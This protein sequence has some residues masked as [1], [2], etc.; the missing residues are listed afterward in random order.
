MS[1]QSQKIN[2]SGQNIENNYVFS[3]KNAKYPTLLSDCFQKNSNIEFQA[4]YKI[5]LDNF[6]GKKYGLVAE[7]GTPKDMASIISLKNKIIAKETGKKH[8]ISREIRRDFI[9]TIKKAMKDH[10]S[11]LIVI[12]KGNELVGCAQLVAYTPPGKYNRHLCVTKDI[13]V[14][15]NFYLKREYRENG[16][17][18]WVLDQLLDQAKSERVFKEIRLNANNPVAVNMYKK[19]GFELYNRAEYKENAHTKDGFRLD[20]S[21]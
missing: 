6:P 21:R 3:N 8:Y 20:F 10:G 9:Y 16:I 7:I 19:R 14:I 18:G 13:G 1:V 11:H 17:M 2:Y 12:K 15:R 4:K 5:P